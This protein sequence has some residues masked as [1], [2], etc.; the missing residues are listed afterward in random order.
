MT[1]SK[2][3]P[4]RRDKPPHD[5]MIE[6]MPRRGHGYKIIKAKAIYGDPNKGVL[7]HW[8][9]EDGSALFNPNAFELWRPL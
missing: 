4:W 7:P 9:L 1:V 8:E 2:S 3:K 5:T 6:V